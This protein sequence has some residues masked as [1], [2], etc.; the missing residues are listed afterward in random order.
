MCP[1]SGAGDVGT[2]LCRTGRG[3]ACDEI[4]SRPLPAERGRW[5]RRATADCGPLKDVFQ[6]EGEKNGEVEA[7]DADRDDRQEERAVEAPGEPSRF[8][9]RR[10]EEGAPWG[11]DR[12][13]RSREGDEAREAGCGGRRRGGRQLRARRRLA[14]PERQPRHV[15]EEP[16]AVRVVR[17]LLHVRGRRVHGLD[18]EGPAARP[19]RGR[20]PLLL[21]PRRELQRLGRGC[22]LRPV[23]EPRRA[24]GVGVRVHERVRQP[25]GAGSQPPARLLEGPLRERR[26]TARKR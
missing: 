23:Q 19:V 13:G 25:A 24:P 4:G 22:R 2:A 11:R 10:G 15:R 16:E 14:Q 7:R 26:R 6:Q 17:F 5:C 12:Q 1:C 18:R 9:Q 20:Q 3:F 21:E 8:V